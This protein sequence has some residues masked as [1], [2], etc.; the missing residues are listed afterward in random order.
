MILHTERLLLRDFTE[1]DA[2]FM[3]GLF[4]DPAFHRYIGDKG[5]RTEEAARAYLT[6]YYIA[7]YALHGYGPYCVINKASGTP[8]GMCG[9]LKRSWLPDPDIGYAF[10]PEYRGRGFAGEAGR[11]VV[12]FAQEVLGLPRLVAIINSDNRDSVKLI[13]TLG[14]TFEVMVRESEDKPELALFALDMVERA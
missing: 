9:I 2:G 8:I 14:F 1:A 4:N 12:E 6:N 10:M 5:V 3:L 13:A 11:A 7:S